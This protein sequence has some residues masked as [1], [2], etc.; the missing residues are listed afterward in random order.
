V[1]S[2]AATWFFEIHHPGAT[3]QNALRKLAAL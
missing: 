3:T 1:I 2:S